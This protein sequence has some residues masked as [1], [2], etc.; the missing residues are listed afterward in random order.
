MI[1]YMA[2][3]YPVPVFKYCITLTTLLYPGLG[4]EYTYVCDSALSL[5][6]QR[7]N[8]TCKGQPPPP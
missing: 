8:K 3:R 1:R 7:T 4:G 6:L 5:G 2:V